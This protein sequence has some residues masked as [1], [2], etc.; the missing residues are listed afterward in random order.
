MCR[1]RRANEDNELDQLASLPLSC[2]LSFSASG[3]LQLAAC[4][5][6]PLLVIVCVCCCHYCWIVKHLASS[7]FFGPTMRE[8]QLRFS[9]RF[10]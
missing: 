5:G 1:D 8:G 10:G 2:S 9:L 4:L 3:S 7:S 6:S